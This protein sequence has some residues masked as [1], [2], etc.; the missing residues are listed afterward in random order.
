MDQALDLTVVMYHYVRDPGDEAEAG[1][2]IPGLP[3]AAFEAQ[4]DLL[5]DIYTLVDWPAV[6]AHLQGKGELPARACLLT[7]DDGVC[8]HYL[9]VFPR[10]RARGLSGL[11]FALARPEGAGLTRPHQ[12]HFLIAALGV[13]QFRARLEAMLEPAARARL[14]ATAAAYVAGPFDFARDNPVEAWR[15]ALQREAEAEAAPAIRQL[16]AEH[17]GQ[18][19]EIAARFFLSPTQTAEMLAGGMHIGGH[20]QSH[21]WL[22]FVD[23]ETLAQEAA[24][25]AAW[26]ARLAP[27]PFAF[28]YPYGGFDDRTPGAMARAGFCAAF[29]TRAQVQHTSTFHIG[30]LDGEWLPPAGSGDAAFLLEPRYA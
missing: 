25:S 7:F 28:A 30:R 4:L 21:P 15:L 9:N 22:D 3:T 12:M 23:D 24:T 8:D 5:T 17:I 26:L 6:R 16:T 27:G 19:E 20:S 2:G 1:S 29:T 18:D 13:D 14:T 11:F 10:L